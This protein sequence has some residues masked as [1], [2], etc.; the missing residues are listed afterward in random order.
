MRIMQIL[1]VFILLLPSKVLA[2][3]PLVSI[4][5]NVL[6]AFE[7]C[8]SLSVNLEKGQLI[9][10]RSPSFDLVCKKINGSETDFSCE[11]FEAG[12]SKKYSE[13]KFTGGSNLG[14]AELRS[15]SGAKVRFLFG[16]SFASF[17]SPADFKAC[18]GFY[19]FEK[20]ALKEQSRRK[21][22]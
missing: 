17:E 3:A 13:E 5:D 21:G 1:L 19:L 20:D 6:L 10:G 11:F 7:K 14:V 4:K 22:Q 9:E 2:S 15:S 16:K 8:K 12:S 18:L